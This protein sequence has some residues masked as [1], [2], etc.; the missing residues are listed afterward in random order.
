MRR[1]LWLSLL[2]TNCSY[3]RIMFVSKKCFERLYTCLCNVWAHRVK[4]GTVILDSVCAFEP[5]KFWGSFMSNNTLFQSGLRWAYRCYNWC[6]G[7]NHLCR[8]KILLIEVPTYDGGLTIYEPQNECE[9]SEDSDQPGHFVG[10]VMSRLNYK[11]AFEPSV[12]I[13][14]WIRE[15]QYV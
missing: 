4:F 5:L 15:N 1:L 10:F 6:L 14:S 12:P 7:R 9:P 8:L 13:V 11:L 2:R 3:L